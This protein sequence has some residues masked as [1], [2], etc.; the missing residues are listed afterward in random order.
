MCAKNMRVMMIF[1]EIT[2]TAFALMNTMTFAIEATFGAQMTRDSSASSRVKEIPACH[3]ADVNMDW[4]L[5]MNEAITYL[6]GWQEG[7]NTMAQAIRAAYLWQKGE[8]YVCDTSLDPPLCWILPAT[9]EGEDIT[10][11]YMSAD[12]GNNYGDIFTGVPGTGPEDGENEGEYE[13]R[14]LVE[15]DVIRREGELLFVLNQYRGLSIVD[16]D[17]EKLL[18][19]TPTV[20]YPRDLYLFGNRAYVLVSYAQDI[21]FEEGKFRVR[22]GSKLYLFNVEDPANVVRESVF[23]FEG[24]LVDSRLVG[25]I[26][27]AV[28]SDYSWYDD[29]AEGEIIDTEEAEISYGTT[30]A[31]SI[32]T[33]DPSTIHIA[34]TVEFSGYG[35]L[36]QATS[37]AIFS[38]AQDY[39]SDTSLITYI[40]IDNGEGDIIVRATATAPGQMAD[41]F[42]MDAWDGALRVVTNTGWP[43]RTTYITTF[44]IGDPDTMRQ[45]GQTTLQSASGEGVFATRFDGARAYIV[46]YLTKDPLFIVDL[47]NPESPQVLGELEIPGWSTHIEPRGDRL[48]ALGV[49]DEGGQR[50]MVS[51]FDVSNP[52]MPLRLDYESFGEGWS[53]SSAYSDVKAFTV[54]DDIIL[55]PFSGWNTG[56]GGYD[57]LQFISLTRDA[58]EPRGYIDLQGSAVRSFAYLDLYYA[59]TQEQLAVINAAD[60]AS[61]TVA[62]SLSLAENVT[63]IAPL[64]SGWA[65]EIISRYDTGDTLLRAKNRNGEEGGSLVLP[66]S[67]ITASFAWNDAVAVV[68]PVYEYEPSYRGYYRVLLV[69]FNDP[70]APAVLGKWDANIEPWYGNWWWGGPYGVEV[71]KR[72]D[73][74]VKSIPYYRYYYPGVASAFLAGDYLVLRGYGSAFS[75]VYGDIIPSEGLAVINLAVEDEPAY[76]GLGYA[77]IQDIDAAANLIYITN[78]RFN[79]LD[80]LQRPICAYYLRTLDPATLEMSEAVNVPGTFLSRKDAGNMLVLKDMQYDDVG[81][82]VTLLRCGTVEGDSF[83]LTDSVQMPFSYGD[84][85][86]D[87]G[88]ICYLGYI[89][90][91]YL[92]EDIDEPPPA[93]TDESG[94]AKSPVL[95]D[96]TQGY[97]LGT[98][99]LSSD[100]KISVGDH[101]DLGQEASCSLLGVK[102]AQAFVSVSGAAIGRFD[103]TGSPPELLSL[104]PVMGY[105]GAIR[106]DADAAYLPLGYSGSLILPLTH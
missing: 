31:V 53:W 27:Y 104:S 103:F 3:P 77:N 54:F 1:T 42:K 63:D 20:G 9:V 55:V 35:N 106:F 101:F 11:Q 17:H 57:R 16:L 22:Y 91:P 28:C 25:T 51:L 2:L 38:V 34:D 52:V 70:L 79:D 105:P 47:S 56:N 65:V 43:E 96:F 78:T 85:K 93:D 62:T 67:N 76:I 71:D 75:T 41:R 69:D 59:V 23:N 83:V 21:T 73:E 89:S 10:P 102:N 68:S 7:N 8:S 98:L 26:L 58:L 94:A 90:P 100:G 29:V 24:D 49:D 61:P 87:D 32:N 64:S 30:W 97:T 92:Y 19:Q 50:V 14:E 48:I 74:D 86:V 5:V 39:E 6:A 80:A 60:L 36:I 81:Q 37:H 12:T 88:F 45:L 4:Q 13:S 95:P 33:A 84:I 40:D 82:L 66:V 72:A 46:T 44:D 15:P 99:I 18:S